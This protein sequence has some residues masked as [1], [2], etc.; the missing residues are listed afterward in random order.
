LRTRIEIA[1]IR[2]CGVCYLITLKNDDD[3]NDYE[4][5]NVLQICKTL[6]SR[7]ALDTLLSIMA[8]SKPVTDIAPENKN[9]I[10]STYKAIRDMEKMGLVAVDK[11]AIDS[12]S[13]VK[14]VALYKSRIKSLEIT[15]DK[16][17]AKLE[18]NNK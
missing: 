15:L 6:A 11:V 16:N 5:K 7:V 4:K 3:D 18:I 10:S 12:S 14:R 13:S 1:V 2:L 9:P 17:G 8:E